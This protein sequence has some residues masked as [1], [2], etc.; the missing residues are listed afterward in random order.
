MK[1]IQIAVTSS[2]DLYALSDEGKVYERR[3]NVGPFNTCTYD[4]EPLKESC[5]NSPA[6]IVAN[7]LVGMV[8]RRIED[9]LIRFGSL[10]HYE[11]T[12][13]VENKGVKALVTA[14]DEGVEV[15]CDN[16]VLK[17]KKVGNTYERIT[18]V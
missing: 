3:L 1:I 17:L 14:T 10:T 8:F 18:T 16:T 6:D 4:W 7:A 9:V 5:G 12:I 11:D 15:S 13:T 2:G